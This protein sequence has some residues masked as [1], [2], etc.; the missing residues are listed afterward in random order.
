[1]LWT[2]I[3]TDPISPGDHAANPAR[4]TVIFPSAR[5]F[6]RKAAPPISATILTKNGGSL[7]AA[8]LASLEWCDE[9]VVLDTGSTD[10][11]LAI[12][13]GFANVSL[14]QLNEPFPGFGE[15]HR[16]AVQL[17]RNDWILSVDADEVVTPELVEEIANLRFDPHTVYTIPFKNYFN[18]KHIR[19]CGWYPDRH[20]RLFNRQ[21][22]NFC[23][24][25]VHERVQTRGLN[26]VTLTHAI[27]HYSYQSNDDFLRKMSHYSR[28]FAEQN[29]GKKQSSTFKA[30]SRS[31][32]AF[33]KS[34]I[35]EW[36]FLQGGEGLTIS[37][38]KSQVVFWKYLKLKEAN[39]RSV[40]EYTGYVAAFML[41]TVVLERMQTL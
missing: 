8:V 38:Y 20:E 39:S 9:V 19:T 37:A 35:V 2:V 28:L 34:Y 16:H 40:M 26:V 32:W 29:Q 21:A 18:G 11:T 15:A 5:P 23:S 7:L 27:A 3:H 22:T 17:A 30:V 6:V 10:A 41:A 1:M 25:E 36:G 24:S 14:H 12:A 4:G 31:A 13:A 33:F